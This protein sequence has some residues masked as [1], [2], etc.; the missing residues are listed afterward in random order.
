[1]SIELHPRALRVAITGGVPYITSEK[2]YRTQQITK[3]E[4]GYDGMDVRALA[5]LAKGLNFHPKIIV[6][7]TII[8][9]RE[10]VCSC[11]LLFRIN[12]SIIF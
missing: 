4:L 3:T 9:W 6:P 11:Y 10:M 8:A 7:S 5:M 12:I 2:K 1:M